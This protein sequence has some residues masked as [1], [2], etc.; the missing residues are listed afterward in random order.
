MLVEGE[1][2]RIPEDCVPSYPLLTNE[3]IIVAPAMDQRIVPTCNLG[4]VVGWTQY[5]YGISVIER[6]QPLPPREDEGEE[7]LNWQLV[8]DPPLANRIANVLIGRGLS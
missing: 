3:R 7:L 1:R 2:G 4:S 5:P 8:V 6:V